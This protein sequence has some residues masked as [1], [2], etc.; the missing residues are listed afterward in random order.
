MISSKVGTLTMEAQ[1]YRSP[2]PASNSDALQLELIRAQV[3][4]TLT[5]SL[6]TSYFKNTQLTVSYLSF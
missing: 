2:P 5:S 4:L 6:V 1:Q 3:P